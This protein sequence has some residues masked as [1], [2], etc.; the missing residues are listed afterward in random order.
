MPSFLGSLESKGVHALLISGQACVAYGASQFT[1]DIDLWVNPARRDFEGLLRIL[2]RAGAK[3]HKL[4]P[5]LDLGFLRKGHGFHFLVPPATYIDVMGVP[6][7]VGP[8]SGAWARARRMITD[9]GKLRVVAPED[10]VLLK[11]TN[12]PGD[13]EA[14][15]N[16]VR[17]RVEEEPERRRVIRWALENTFDADDLIDFAGRAR[18]L[19][20]P[21]PRRPALAALPR[22]REAA[23]L[24]A[25]EAHRVQERGRRYWLP[26]L[27]ELK[28][29]RATGELLTPGTPLADL[30]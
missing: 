14:I 23:R 21:R 30:L 27:R 9:W 24:L 20:V 19:G 25:L 18:R 3:A 7:R 10:L 15:S 26:L 8:F 1:E 6:P 12:R 4:T 16:L 2:A 5:P 28:R 17:L 11:R 29:L 22:R 13:Y